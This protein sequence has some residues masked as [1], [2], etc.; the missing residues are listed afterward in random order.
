MRS[1]SVC[2]SKRNY[3]RQRK[4]QA[5]LDEIDAHDTGPELD[6]DGDDWKSDLLD[7]LLEM[8][9]DAFERLAQRLL[10]EAGFRNVEVLGRTGDGGLDGV[11]TNRL[12]CQ[13]PRQVYFCDPNSPWQRCTNENTNGLLLQY[14]P[15]GTDMSQLTQHDLV[16]AAYSLNTRL[17]QTLNWM[18]PSDKLAEALQ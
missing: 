2:A 4:E 10:R 1:Q 14:F 16:Q 8:E 3:Y 7:R 15:K 17:R 9:S 6:V 13:L 12:T 5:A 18:T 11:G